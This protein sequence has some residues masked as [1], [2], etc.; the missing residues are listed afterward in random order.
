MRGSQRGCG[1]PS[2]EW[3]AGRN[4]ALAHL[5]GV[6]SKCPRPPGAQLRGAA[7]KEIWHVARKLLLMGLL[8]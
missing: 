5:L 4:A 1:A 3:A 7:S 2:S 6:S 8:V